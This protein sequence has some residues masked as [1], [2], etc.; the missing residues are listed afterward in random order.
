MPNRLAK[1]TSPYL[2]QHADNP[3]DWYPWGPEALAKAQSDQ[4]PIFL[5]VG[6]AACHWCHVMEHESF[7]D[8]QTARYLNDHFVP[9][10]VDRE[11]R[12]DLD[13]IYMEAV[14]AMT[15][16][17]GWPMSVF[18]TPDGKPFH[19][20][21]YYPNTPRYGMPS[22]RDVLEGIA[23][24]WS[25]RRG[26]AEDSGNRVAA[27]IA[28]EQL[29][30]RAPSA[31]AATAA[32]QT[33]LGGT[34]GS[35]NATP[36]DER[37]LD[38]AILDAAVARLADTFDWANGS[39]G[40]A[41]K[42]PQSM[43]LEFLLRRVVGPDDVRAADATADEDPARER[44]LRMVTKTLD[45]MADGGIRDQLGGGFHR[46]STDEVWLAPHFEKMLYD[47]AQL[48]RVYVHAWQLTGEM[49]YREIAESTIDYVA[50][51][52]TVPE[53]GFTAS[54]D[55][56]SEGEE[57]RFYV[58]TLPEI[59]AVLGHSGD[60]GDDAALFA[61][62]YDVRTIGNWE[63]KTILRR[64]RSDA[65]LAAL[66]GSPDTTAGSPDTTAGASD[67]NA[68]AT[69]PNAGAA[70]SN[71]IAARLSRAR[72]ALF[73]ARERRIRPARDDKALASWNG[74]ML[75]AVAEAARVLDRADYRDLAERNATFLLQRLRT[76]EGRLRRSWKDGRATLN[77]YLEDYANVAEGLLALYETTFDP[78]WFVSAR[79]L[80]DAVLEHFADPQGG[81]FDT[82]DD[83]EAL[84]ARPK[85]LQD[86]AV[87]S[88]SAMAVTV[89][90]KLAA[91][92]GEGRYRDAAE[93]ALRTVEPY[94]GRHP[95][96]FAQWLSALDFAL[97]PV[98]EIAIAGDPRAA[99][100]Q[101]LLAAARS[102]YRPH[103]VVAA[104]LPA[105][106]AVPAAGI[107]AAAA[108]A[109]EPIP[110]LADRPLV[111]GRPTAYVCLG[112][113]CD[114]PVT[115]AA[116]LAAQLSGQ[117]SRPTLATHLTEA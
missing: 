22:F 46:Y 3:V 2:L 90:L 15:G 113:V 96:G 78:R 109:A 106:S 27:A 1:E 7:E 64:V 13:A 52:M 108:E 110:L 10:K 48:A 14:Q 50:R 70:D 8:E 55:A 75:A 62:A 101:P 24:V 73:E 79:E 115:D 25:E 112:F 102:G 104:A 71:G 80:M 5:S 65:E 12:P 85:G 21:T 36:R 59:E 93:G 95:T 66:F 83:H 43:T 31:P 105:A 76:P 82:S 39:W 35:A 100:T 54:Q 99:D 42:F 60:L 23:E 89:L 117:P 69:D 111:D 20:G 94:L 74:L 47:N 72:Q 41:P 98:R 58:W 114:L 91:W 19:G 49:R 87:P 57:G 29:G 18:L 45:A 88:G 11:E 107:P 61:T 16:R 28:A 77:G 67:S 9:V 86:N 33:S 116:R 37:P 68:E 81:F 84:V 97:A 17:G 32:T 51:E 34:S 38:P 44:L 30:R 92:T 40:G 6:Y 63:G 53:G 103:Q 56:D 4:K 26:E